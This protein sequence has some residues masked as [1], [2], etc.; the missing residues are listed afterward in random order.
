MDKKTYNT[1]R[2][3][4]AVLVAAACSISVVRGNYILPIIIGITAAFVLYAMKKKVAGVLADERDYQAAGNA[5]LWSLSIYAVFAAISSMYLMAQRSV[6]PGFELAAQI[7]AYSA[8]A[9]LIMQS[10][11]FKYFQGKK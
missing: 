5:A 11:L 3:I 2:I 10:L 1:L 8:C 7:L 4:F 9:L 6:D